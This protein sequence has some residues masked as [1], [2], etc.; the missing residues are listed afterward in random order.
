MSTAVGIRTVVSSLALLSS[1]L[2][3]AS[4]CA[5]DCALAAQMAAIED[6][7]PALSEDGTVGFADPGLHANDPNWNLAV[8]TTC[9]GSQLVGYDDD[10]NPIYG[11]ALPVMIGSYWEWIGPADDASVGFA[12]PNQH[13]GDPDWELVLVTTGGGSFL[14]GSDDDGNPIY[15]VALP[16]VIGSWW[17]YVG[18]CESASIPFADG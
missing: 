14:V 10:G 6:D 9:G 16:V 17:K 18:C 13:A 1:L 3:G 15:G 8:I 12:D 4:V 2:F 11:V 7:R 5:Q